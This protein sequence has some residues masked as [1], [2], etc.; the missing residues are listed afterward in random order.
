VTPRA[1]SHLG[2]SFKSKAQHQIEFEK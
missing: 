2:L 1:Y